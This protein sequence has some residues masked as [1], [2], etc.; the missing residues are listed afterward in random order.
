MK[1]V[2]SLASREQSQ[3]RAVVLI[4][5]ALKLLSS[6]EKRREF[7]RTYIRQDRYLESIRN[8]DRFVRLGKAFDSGSKR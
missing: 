5:T 3:A 2:S 1:P 7:W 8:N 6:D 4:E